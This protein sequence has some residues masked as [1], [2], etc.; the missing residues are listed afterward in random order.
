VTRLPRDLT[1]IDLIK[2]L[3]KLGYLE[4]REDIL[5]ALFD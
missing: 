1:G 5:A 3:R 2:A 4:T